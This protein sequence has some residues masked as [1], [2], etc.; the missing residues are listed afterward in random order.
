MVVVKSGHGLLGHEALKSALSQKWIDEM[1]WFFAGWYKFGTAKSYFNN[2]WVGIIKNG[3][4]LLNHGTLK[5]G[6]SHKSFDKLSRLI[7]WFLHAD[8]DGIIF[9]LMVYPL[10]IFDKC[11]CCGT[12]AVVLPFSQKWPKARFFLY[13][14][15]FCHWFL[16]GTYF[17][18]SCYCTRFDLMG[19]DL[20]FTTRFWISTTEFFVII[21]S[22]L[23][24]ERNKNQ[25]I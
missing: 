25:W 7:E 20:G 2:Y 12:T 13:F 10:F 8:S 9:G 4:G 5:S 23:I 11:K 22:F 3:W 19:R 1:S 21:N 16:L 24:T 6:V 17:N 18:K 15:K 14:E